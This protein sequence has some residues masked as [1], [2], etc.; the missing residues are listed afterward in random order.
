[1]GKR[2][3]GSGSGCFNVFLNFLT[4]GVLLL[5]VMLGGVFVAIYIDP[6]VPFN[7]FP[8]RLN[9]SLPPIQPTETSV[10]L[11]PPTWTPTIEPTSTPTPTVTIPAP[12]NTL[13]V[14]SPIPTA[15]PYSV[16]AGTPAYTSNFLNN[17]GCQ[18][19]GVAGQVF[20]DEQ[21]D[22]PD[23]WIYL[24]GR[25]SGSLL[26]LLSLPGSAPGYGEGG[27]EFKLSDAPVASEDSVWIE[28]IDPSGYPLAPR[29]YLTTKDSCDENL[30][31]VNWVRSP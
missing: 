18:W 29:V 7:P 14:V 31:L 30:I 11:L 16:Q 21:G 6:G 13:P 28:L 23:V 25:L 20:G 15:W 5:S 19:M 9:P 17:L 8:P 22:T 26:D 27:Y 2:N 24:G 3:K 10:A 4:I 12:T 1:M